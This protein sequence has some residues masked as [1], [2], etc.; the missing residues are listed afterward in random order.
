MKKRKKEAQ[1]SNNKKKSKRILLKAIR[2][3]QEDWQTL[4]EKKGMIEDKE[5]LKQMADDIIELQED[6]GQLES[7][8]LTDPLHE[9]LETPSPYGFIKTSLIDAAVSFNYQDPLDS[10]LCHLL[11]YASHYS[12][13][14]DDD[15]LMVLWSIEQRLKGEE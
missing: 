10:D 6:I 9:I 13:V 2:K 4:L 1:S 15:K 12:S 3:L 8:P 11:K 5:F 14:F 7:D